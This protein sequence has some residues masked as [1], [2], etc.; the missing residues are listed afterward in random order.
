[1]K[2]LHN[3][4]KIASLISAIGIVWWIQTAAL[5]FLKVTNPYFIGLIVIFIEIL[6]CYG[7]VLYD[8]KKAHRSDKL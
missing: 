6:I 7:L 5:Q 8:N 2:D 4:L 3:F 1:M